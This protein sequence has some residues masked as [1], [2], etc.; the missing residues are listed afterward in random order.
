M[1]GPNERD[2]IRVAM[3]R[4]LDGS[5]LTSDG[6]L[7]VVSLAAG[8]GA[9]R[10]VLTHRHTDLKDEFY[11]RVHLQGHV[12]RSEAKLREDLAEPQRRL[13]EAVEDRKNLRDTVERLTRVINVLTVENEALHTQQREQ[14]QSTVVPLR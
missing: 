2:A 11:A 12:P 4:L 10:H 9:K 5:P 6:A 14:K 1:T 7:T 8:A 13:A 3:Q